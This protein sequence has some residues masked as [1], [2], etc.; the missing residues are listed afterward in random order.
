MD[1][2]HLAAHIK[3]HAQ[4]NFRKA[5]IISDHG[6][7]SYG[8]LESESNRIANFLNEKIFRYAPGNDCE[9][10]NVCII[11]DRCPEIIISII[12]ILKAGLVFVPISPHIPPKRVEILLQETNT[13]WVITS[14]QYYQRFEELFKKDC[15]FDV[16]LIDGIPTPD[17]SSR[18]HVIEYNDGSSELD[19]E[20]RYNKY[21]YIYFT[22]GS[23]GIPKGVLGRHKSLC[24]FIDWEINQF[25]INGG[26]H[27]SQ[28]TPPTF[29]PYLRDIFVPLLAGGTI[30]IPDYDT[31]MHAGKLL[32]WTNKN[33][34]ELMHIV[35]SLFKVILREINSPDNFLD[36]KY[37][38]L[39]GELLRGNDIRKFID[40]FNDRI[41]LVNIYGPTETTL[42]KFFYLVQPSDVEKT[43]IPVG[44]TIKGAEALIL[45]EQGQKCLTGNIGEIHIRTPYISS[46]YFNNKE[47]N[48][49]VFIKNPFSDDK[50]DIIYK[51]GD[52]G[53]VLF[54][55]NVELTGRLDDQVKIRGYRVE[56]REI[57]NL[58]LSVNHIKEAVVVDK[59][60]K[61]GEKY[62][63]A[64]LVLENS[65]SKENLPDLINQV[66]VTLSKNLPSYMFPSSFIP[67]NDL[68]L[69]PNGK[70]NRFALRQMEIKIDT[71]ETYIAPRDD[72]EK[73]IAE[74]WKNV[75]NLD[76]IGINDNFFNAGGTSLNAIQVNS[77]I[78]EMVG[79]D[80]SIVKFF[81]FPTIDLFVKFL[82]NNSS[83]SLDK[84]ENNLKRLDNMSQ[85]RNQ[86][87]LRKEKLKDLKNE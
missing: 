35:P 52:M 56:P 49:E 23:M 9:K 44:K 81:E 41:R 66:K 14:W 73:K 58:L 67:L 69:N 59:E 24:H 1:F 75:L 42:A 22:S 20:M 33:K 53:R 80:I 15:R 72:L 25:G 47:L 19:F 26:F 6:V 5:A 61:N 71:S 40:I 4:T 34:I 60:D 45:D 13:Q 79:K 84:E 43:I 7:L 11:L 10:L 21:C 54:D 82:A 31:L 74:I 76:K 16:L 38:L 29:D 32:T 77:R 3:R 86:K 87:V 57:E 68:P 46:G 70:V 12:G 27:V 48:K 63:C 83:E 17:L 28:F 37:I 55:G 65:C 8:E 50:N 78:S 30:C 51:T 18:V 62:L 2:Q 85:R 39:A 64:F 36:L